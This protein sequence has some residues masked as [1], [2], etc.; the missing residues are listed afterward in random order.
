MSSDR[1]PNIILLQDYE[2]ANTVVAGVLSLKGC[3]VHKTTNSESCLSIVGDLK[4]K[5]DVALIKKEIAFSKNSMVLQNIKKINPA[6]IVIIL[7]DNGNDEGTLQEQQ[8]DE[9]VQTPVS[10]ENLADKILM[11]L[12]KKELKRLKENQLKNDP[13]EQ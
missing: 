5:A 12:A 9:L 11:L 7:A 2:D 1:V 10:A 13:I 3:H 6:I 4:E 8:I